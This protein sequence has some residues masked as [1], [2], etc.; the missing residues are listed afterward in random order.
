M[1]MAGA[2]LGAGMPIMNLAVQNEFEQHDL[3]AATSASQLFRGLGSTIGTAVFGSI[4]AT[5]ITTQLGNLQDKAYI[6]SLQRQ[7]AAAQLLGD[8]NADTAINL[9]TAD[10]KKAVTNGAAQALA[11][12]PAPVAEQALA[13]L[14]Q[15]Q[16]SFA[17]DVV[18]AFSQSLRPVF[19][20]AAVLM[21]LATLAVA[22]IREGKLRSGHG[23]PAEI[24]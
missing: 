20:A 1:L 21:L 5:G 19:V 17:H 18:E 14:K 23:T 6:Q 4:L 15:Q 9:N 8:L 11:N 12:A 7:P 2:G 13:K 10:V 24:S 3:G 16:D 22:S